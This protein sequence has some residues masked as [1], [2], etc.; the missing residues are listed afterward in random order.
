MDA[1]T[2]DEDLKMDSFKLLS[3]KLLHTKKKLFCN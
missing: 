3:A 1:S 2:M